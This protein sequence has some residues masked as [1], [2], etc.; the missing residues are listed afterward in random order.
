MKKSVTIT[1]NE[2]IDLVNIR[3]NR[4][5]TVYHHN[6]TG[7]QTLQNVLGQF[8]NQGISTTAYWGGSATIVFLSRSNTRITAVANRLKFMLNP[9]RV[10]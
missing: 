6:L 7:N 4:M 1:Y 3:R 10:L 8:I 2:L 9:D 5:V